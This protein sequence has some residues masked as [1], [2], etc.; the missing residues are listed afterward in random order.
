MKFNR[1]SGIQSILN[2]IYWNC[3]L[4]N[5]FYEIPRT[6]ISI[7]MYNLNSAIMLL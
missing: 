1:A 6:Q 7:E 2:S 5:I 4:G 3:F